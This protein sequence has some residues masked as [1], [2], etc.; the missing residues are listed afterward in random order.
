[1]SPIR[2]SI[3]LFRAIVSMSDDGNGISLIEKFIYFIQNIPDRME[4][5]PIYRDIQNC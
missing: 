5:P 2:L 3:S 4:Q 1:M